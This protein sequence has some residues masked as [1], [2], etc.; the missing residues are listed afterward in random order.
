MPPVISNL[1]AVG[2]NGSWP[3]NILFKTSFGFAISVIFS[4]IEV[5]FA[6]PALPVLKKYVLGFGPTYVPGTSVLRATSTNSS[7][8]FIVF[9][10]APLIPVYPFPDISSPKCQPLVAPGVS[11]GNNASFFVNSPK[12]CFGVCPA[13]IVGNCF[14]PAITAGSIIVLGNSVN[15]RVL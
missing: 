8:V 2:S 7:P 11:P 5:Y 1:I 10:A 13:L 3:P 9:I 6:S 12:N 15:P 4:L 14:V